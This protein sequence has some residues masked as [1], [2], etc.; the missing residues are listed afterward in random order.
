[1]VIEAQESFPEKPPVLYERPFSQDFTFFISRQSFS[2]TCSELTVNGPFELQA[3][4][5]LILIS[6]AASW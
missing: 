2:Y 5:K 4:Q 3:L 1:M 6:L